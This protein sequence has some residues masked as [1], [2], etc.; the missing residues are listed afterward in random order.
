MICFCTHPGRWSHTV[1]L[2]YSEV[3]RKLPPSSRF[4]SMSYFSMKVKLWQATK[5]ARVMR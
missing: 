1:S 4:F 5:V 2:S 3:R